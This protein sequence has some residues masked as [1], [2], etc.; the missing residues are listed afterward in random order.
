MSIFSCCER[1]DETKYLHPC[2]CPSA[3]F[4]CYSEAVHPTL[5]GFQEFSNSS[6][7]ITPSSP[8][9]RYK[10]KVDYYVINNGEAKGVSI[11][12]EE[13]EEVGDYYIDGEGD[14]DYTD[15]W[16]WKKVTTRS[17]T[18]CTLVE[19]YN[20]TDLLC[21]DTLNE[22]TLS[23]NRTCVDNSQDPVF[24]DSCSGLSNISTTVSGSNPTLTV[25]STTTQ[26]L[27]RVATTAQ[28]RDDQVG[29]STTFRDMVPGTGGGFLSCTDDNTT[30]TTTTGTYVQTSNRSITLSEE[31]TEDDAIARETPVSGN[32][33][34][35]TWETRSTGFSWLKRTSGYT[36]VCGNLIAGLEYE[37]KPVIK[38]RTAVIGSYGEWEDVTVTPVT[39]TATGTTETIDESGEPIPLDHIQGY[40]YGIFGVSIEKTA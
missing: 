20:P 36:I 2:D 26:N 7:G 27:N 38:K 21:T 13:E 34:T 31:D 29:S 25:T 37:V 32:T 39:F 5:Q 24:G 6:A 30:T 17:L 22:S 1:E 14:C 40:E 35:S 18:G 33:C 10:K 23:W 16:R 9:R 8:P 11:T 19:S 15:Y 28:S 4:N 12:T 3:R